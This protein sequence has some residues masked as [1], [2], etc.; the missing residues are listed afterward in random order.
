MTV[1]IGVTTNFSKGLGIHFKLLRDA[2]L[3]L[4]LQRDAALIVQPQ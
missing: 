3:E 2:A 1:H 4:A